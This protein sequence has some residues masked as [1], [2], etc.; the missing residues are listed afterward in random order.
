MNTSQLTRIEH[1]RSFLFVPA[2]RPDRI[3]KALTCGADVVIVDLEDSVAPGDKDHAR[4]QLHDYLANNPQA[5]VLVRINSSSSPEFANDLTLCTRFQNIRGVM[6]PKAETIQQVE[7]VA[8]YGKPIWPIIESA[9]GLAALPSLSF[10]G[11]IARLTF[12]ALDLAADLSLESGTPGANT[13]LDQCRYQLIVASRT[14]RLPPPLESV[15]PDIQDMARVKEAA[16]RAME[17]GFS[18]MLCIHPRQVT[19]IHDAFT[20]DADV[21]DWANRV[22]AMSQCNDGAFQL[23]GQMVDEPVVLRART[24]LARAGFK[25]SSP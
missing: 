21:I 10:T 16:S 4:Q 14:A 25:D 1:D 22:I 13:L 11:G 7:R 2:T 17:M 3:A 15:V 8:S 18:G 6:L 23:D 20:P 19:A 5:E 9:R 24:L 12:G